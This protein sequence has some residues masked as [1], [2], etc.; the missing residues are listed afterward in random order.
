MGFLSSR[1]RDG[2][3]SVGFR[4]E[5]RGEGAGSWGGVSGV[6]ALRRFAG[7]LGSEETVQYR[8]GIRVPCGILAWRV[9]W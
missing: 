3:R 1:T 5:R 7:S 8:R 2:A 9:V 6:E 4:V